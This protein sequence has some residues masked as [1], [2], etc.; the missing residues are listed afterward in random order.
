MSFKDKYFN[1]NIG[2][3][4]NE[5]NFGS[6]SFEKVEDLRYGTN[7]HQPGAFYKIK[8]KNEQ[9]FG[10]Y[11][12]LKQG[13]NGL[14]QTNLEDANQAIKIIKYL[15][16][17]SV[18]V[19]KHLNP[20]GVAMQ[21]K[22]EALVEVYKKAR[23]VD[24]Q[25]AFGSSVIFNCEVDEDTAVEIMQSI[26]ENVYAPSYSKKALEIFNDFDTYKKNKQIR[27]VQLPDI[28]TLPKYMEDN[29]EPELKVL[30]D[31]SLI[32]AMPYLTRIKNEKDLILAHTEHKEKGKIECARKPSS[33]EEL[34]MLLSWYVNIGVRSNGIVIVKDGVTLAV[35]T[36]EQ[37]RV[38]AMDQ[39]L[40]KALKKS[41]LGISLEGAVVSSDGFF[42]FR[43]SIDL[44][45]KAGI[46]AIVQPGGSLRD[47]EVIEA[48]NEH[49]IAMV[50]TDERCFSHH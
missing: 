50:F 44:C 40:N 34:D 11:K 36:G 41:K 48:C 6:L 45:A 26:V 24:A 17:P 25:A 16:R 2:N 30:Q 5:L 9:P 32:L 35:G 37:D 14:S 10:N 18:A 20:S 3:F 13:K 19:M 28:S 22:G 46:K 21:W 15:D 33:D 4:P 38:G 23:D 31:G 42:P 7:P 1:K 12:L 49:Q 27:I 29:A 47:Y 8:G 39:A 43:D